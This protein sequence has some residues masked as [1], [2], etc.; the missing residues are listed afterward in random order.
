MYDEL[1]V[2]YKLQTFLELRIQIIY[3]VSVYS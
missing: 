3:V 2:R 1:I